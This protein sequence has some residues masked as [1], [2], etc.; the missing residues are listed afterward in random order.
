MFFVF[1]KYHRVGSARIR[2]DVFVQVIDIYD[3]MQEQKMRP[4][5][6]DYFGLLSA[7][8][9]HSFYVNHTSYQIEVPIAGYI[10]FTILI[11]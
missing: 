4:L 1:F 3:Y 7:I 8:L 10:M 2:K 9:S 11:R 5:R 6:T